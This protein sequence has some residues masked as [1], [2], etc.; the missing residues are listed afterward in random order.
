[1][2]A[3]TGVTIT[4]EPS[5]DAAGLLSAING[6]TTAVHM[7]MYL[8][9]DT[10]FIDALVSLHQA[11]KDVKIVLNQNF[12]TGTGSA[13]TNASSQSAL[14]SAGVDVHWSPTTTGFDNY[15][16]EKTVIID[17]GTANAQA[18]IMTMNLDPS[19]PRYNREYLALDTNASETRMRGA[20]RFMRSS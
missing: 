12:P 19:A 17:P 18:W 11:N 6:A 14:S 1:M 10:R 20:M 2:M 16:H 4:V 9:S 3:S 15:T 5:D 13:Q 7:T 8:L